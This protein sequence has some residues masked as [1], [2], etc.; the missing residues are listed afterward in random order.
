VRYESDRRGVNVFSC[1]R[2]FSRGE[3]VRP[4]RPHT[5]AQSPCR[6]L[7]ASMI[8]Y[9][10]ALDMLGGGARDMSTPPASGR[11]R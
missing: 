5:P 2:F 9:A 6:E 11:A 8:F 3:D 10:A 4:Q 1:A 7:A